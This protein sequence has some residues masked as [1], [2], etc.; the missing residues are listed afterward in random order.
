MTPEPFASLERIFSKSFGVLGLKDKLHHTEWG[1]EPTKSHEKAKSEISPR[2]GD[3]HKKSEFLIP[4]LSNED[5]GL[6]H[7]LSMRPNHRNV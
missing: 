4:S 3:A 7:S 1:L 5:H 2:I 6:P